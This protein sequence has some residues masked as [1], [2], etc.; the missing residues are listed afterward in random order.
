MLPI[1][2]AVLKQTF[3]PLKFA[4]A[5]GSS[6]FP[7]SGYNYLQERPLIDLMIVPENTESFHERNMLANSV[8]YSKIARLLGPRIVCKVQRATTGVYF[9]TKV[10]LTDGTVRLRCDFYTRLDL[11]IRHRRSG[12]AQKGTVGME[13]TVHCGQNA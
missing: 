8:H 7:Q 5:Y 11:Q 9:N 10:P 13:R 1:S 2:S 12:N 3:G 6:A 4:F